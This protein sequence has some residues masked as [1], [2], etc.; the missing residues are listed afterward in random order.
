MV[1]TTAVFMLRETTKMVARKEKMWKNDKRRMLKGQTS[2][3]PNT[4][5]FLEPDYG[6]IRGRPYV[7]VSSVFGFG[8]VL[9][10][11]NISI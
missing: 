10:K 1:D 8:V 3:E 2:F 7:F 6:V 5:P 9:E 4:V 11:L